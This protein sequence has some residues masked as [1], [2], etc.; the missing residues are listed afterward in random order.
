VPDSPPKR[1]WWTA[2]GPMSL[3]GADRKSRDRRA[4]STGKAM[5]DARRRS[6]LVDCVWTCT[7]NMNSKPHCGAAALKAPP[8]VFRLLTAPARHFV[9]NASSPPT[10]VHPRLQLASSLRV[11]ASLACPIFLGALAPKE[12]RKR[13][14]LAPVIFPRETTLADVPDALT[15]RNRNLSPSA[16][17]SYGP[18]QGIGKPALRVGAKSPG[19]RVP[20]GP[21]AR[22]FRFRLTTRA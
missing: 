4:T 22:A 18:R 6:F 7:T 8:Q 17:S 14:R 16:R 15:R 12:D 13:V 19:S 21:V 10:R 3:N 5:C 2:T 1:R 11:S 9:S 20:K